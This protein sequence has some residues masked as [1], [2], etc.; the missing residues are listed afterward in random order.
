[1]AGEIILPEVTTPS[2]PAAGKDA[3]FVSNDATPRVKRVNSAGTVITSLESGVAW[4]AGSAT[5]PPA[6]MSSGTVLTTPTAGALE[7]DGVAFYQSP[8]ASNRGV[9]NVSHVAVLTADYTLTDSNTAQKAFNSSTNGAITVGG[10][11]SYLLDALYIITNTG[12]T[13]HTWA[14]LFAGTATLTSIAYA[15]QAY[16]GITSAATITAVSGNYTVAATALVVTAASV[17]ATEQVVIQLH[18][19]IRTNAAGTI[20]PQIQL[21]AATTGT[22]KMLKNSYIKL[23]PIGSDTVATIGNWS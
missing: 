12:T 18:G 6:Q 4:P 2:T 1:M 23:S 22:S 7:Y 16:T 21:S 3:F 15:A 13:S 11:T 10:S 19:V 20:I 5:V 17:S 14:T 9:T 8:I